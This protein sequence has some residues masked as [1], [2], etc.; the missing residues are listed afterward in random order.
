MEM[1]CKE[2]LVRSMSGRMNL[3]LSSLS[4]EIGHKHFDIISS[5]LNGRVMKLAPSEITADFKKVG[6]IVTL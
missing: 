1:E 6:T 4:H 3:Y 2:Y 5:H